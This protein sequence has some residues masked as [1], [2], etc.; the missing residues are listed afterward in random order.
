M[1]HHCSMRIYAIL[2]KTRKNY[3][4]LT[5]GLFC[6]QSVRLLHDIALNE[7]L[8]KK[9]LWLMI[10]WWYLITFLL[11]CVIRRNE[12]KS[13]LLFG[14]L[15]MS[16]ARFNRA[17]I[18]FYN[19]TIIVYQTIFMWTRS[20]AA[21]QPGNSNMI[22]IFEQSQACV[23]ASESVITLLLSKISLAMNDIIFGVIK[24]GSYK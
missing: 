16:R 24:E 5:L 21:Q 2:Q 15:F 20:R 8:K 10:L 11:L 19:I 22:M 17:R 3:Q 13:G 12:E 18:M 4:T 7:K 1:K 9:P 14:T 6:D 23:C